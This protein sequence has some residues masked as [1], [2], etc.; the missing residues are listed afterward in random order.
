MP[1]GDDLNEVWADCPGY[2]GIYEISTLGS[3]RRVGGRMKKPSSD[4]RGYLLVQLWAGN[5]G[6]AAMI[7]RLVAKAFVPGDHSLSVNHKDGNKLNNTPKNLEWISLAQNTKHQ[8]DA[9][10]ANK[11]ACFKPSKIPAEDRDQIRRR[12]AAG[13]L[14]KKIAAEYGCSQPLISWICK[15]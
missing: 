14:Q 13:E 5:K 9:G 15:A 12:V 6:K 3:V 4:K 8:H 2:Q 11:S 7:H 10:L 1:E